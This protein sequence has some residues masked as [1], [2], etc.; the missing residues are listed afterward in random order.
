MTLKFEIDAFRSGLV[1]T[2]F[3]GQNLWGTNG[4]TR[5]G[6]VHLGEENGAGKRQ[7]E[8]AFIE[9]FDR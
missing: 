5:F 8:I 6:K 2:L 3:S 9:C 7:T 4:L 1:T